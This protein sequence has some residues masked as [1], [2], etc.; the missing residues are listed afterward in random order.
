[1]R[2]YPA[3]VSVNLAEPK[4]I[5]G[6]FA[7]KPPDLPLTTGKGSFGLYFLLPYSGFAA[8]VPERRIWVSQM[9]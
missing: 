5:T 8:S 3:L 1:M 2:E 7:H 4:R 9:T 6:F